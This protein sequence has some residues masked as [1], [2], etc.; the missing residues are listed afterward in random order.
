MALGINSADAEI[1]FGLHTEHIGKEIVGTKQHIFLETLDV[2]LEEVRLGNQAFGK[3]SVQAADSHRAGLFV[4]RCFKTTAPLRVHRAG[5][6]ICWIEIE[7]PLLV[8]I[9]RR[10]S[11]VMSVRPAVGLFSQLIYGFLDG[12]ES[13]NDQ[14]IA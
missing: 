1:G 12:I 6:G 11:M 5:G 9:T 7:H 2:D 8:R 13:M 10:D 4:R 14:V 3:E